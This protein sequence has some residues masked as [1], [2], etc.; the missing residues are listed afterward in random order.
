MR[1]CAFVSHILNFPRFA[2]AL[3]Y[4][5]YCA[6]WLPMSFVIFNLLQCCSS[7]YIC[8]EVNDLNIKYRYQLISQDIVSIF[9]V[10]HVAQLSHDVKWEKRQSNKRKYLFHFN[11]ITLLLI[12]LNLM[13]TSTRSLSCVLVCNLT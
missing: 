4:N 11:N 2:I 7:K 5:K 13:N 8:Q 12:W 10:T 1:N 9:Y 3:A 6:I